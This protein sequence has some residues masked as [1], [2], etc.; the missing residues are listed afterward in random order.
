MLCVLFKQSTVKY[1][2]HL[3]LSDLSKEN[4]Y[5]SY[6]WKLIEYF[7]SNILENNNFFGSVQFAEYKNIS[8]FEK[9]FFPL[10]RQNGNKF[11]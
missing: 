10:V 9:N 5:K 2:I 6:K 7:E 3:I 11:K 4:D 8:D 1:E